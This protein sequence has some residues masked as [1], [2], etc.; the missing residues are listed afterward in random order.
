MNLYYRNYI[1]SLLKLKNTAPVHKKSKKKTKYY[2]PT[3]SILPGNSQIFER[4]IFT[5]CLKNWIIL[6]KILV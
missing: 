2:Y 4:S 1:T 5:Q 6:L 3:V